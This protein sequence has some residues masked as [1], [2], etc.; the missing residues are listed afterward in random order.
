MN[1]YV[2]WHANLDAIISHL[3]EKNAHIVFMLWGS[4]AQSRSGRINK[5]VSL[6][7]ISRHLTIHIMLIYYR[8]IWYWNQ[9]ILHP[10]R[11]IVSL[12]FW[13]RYLLGSHPFFRWFLWMWPFQS[14]QWIPCQE[15]SFGYQLELLVWLVLFL[16]TIQSIHM[17][18][19]MKMIIMATYRVERE[20]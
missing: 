13:S 15:C 2:H 10:C 6:V 17:Y 5:S 12:T 9:C 8:N 1:E 14:C 3:S 7:F 4:H 18:L 19:L 16:F 11:P 20:R